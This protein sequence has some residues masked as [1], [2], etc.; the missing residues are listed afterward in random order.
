M[1]WNIRMVSTYPPRRCGIETFC[2]DLSN[3]LSQFTGEIGHI[4]VAAID[5][6]HGPYNIPV[7]LVIDQFNP[8]SWQQVTKEII[9]RAKE[10]NN[11]TA[12]VLQHEYGLDVDEQGRGDGF[13]RNFIEMAKACSENGLTCLVYLHTVLENPSTEQRQTIIDLAKYSN[14]LIVTTE[15]AIDILESEI[16]SI[17]HLKLKHIDHGVRMHHPTQFDRFTLKSELGI[18]DVFL[19]TTLG[20]LSPGKGI[21]YSIRGYGRFVHESCTPAQRQHIVYLIGG[22]CHPEFV[23][24]EDG[25]YYREF[26]AEIDKALEESDLKWCKANAIE[27][28]DWFNNDIVFLDM[29]L[30]ESSLLKFYG[31]TNAMILPYLN[32]EQI[33]SGILADTIGSGRVAISTK[34]RYA[35][36]LIYSN[37]TC[38]PGV[39]IGRFARGIL[40]DP[41]DA[42][43]KQIA[44]ALD[45]LVFEKEKRIQ[46]EKQAHQRGYQMR[47][48]NSAWAMVQYVEFVSEDKEITTG[49]GI[50]FLR[51]KPSKLT[52]KTKRTKDKLECANSE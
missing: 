5:N 20:L 3:A 42:A 9:S 43:V 16:Y 21:Q 7:D 45:Y 15:S 36:E 8:K 52:I 50:K 10:S 28:I 13:G 23:K 39:R 14:G 51:E 32:T 48:A 49:R 29:F 22:Q 38:P 40:V 1:A 44:Q 6:N 18:N 25:K 33:S 47:W 19:V 24:A 35:L 37:K 11:S 4:R 2:R 34:F 12:V 46:M 41:G 27:G 17:S 26:M 31:A 30:D